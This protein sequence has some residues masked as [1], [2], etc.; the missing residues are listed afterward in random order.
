MSGA[1]LVLGAGSPMVREAA[2]LLAQRGEA[3]FLA[4]HDPMELERLA[5]DLRIRWGGRVAVGRFDALDPASH[6]ALFTRVLDAFG[7]LDRV[8]MASGYLGPVP[9]ALEGDEPGRILALNFSGLLPIL[10]LC[11]AHFERR[12]SG[13]ILGI[14]SV[15]G[16]RGRQSN[17][18]YGSAKGG[19]ALW[20]Q[21]LRNRLH[22]TGVRVVTFKPGFVDTAMTFGKPGIF[23]VASP[24][25]AGAALVRALDGGADIVYFPAFWRVIMALVRAIPERIFKGMKL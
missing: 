10:G 24:E 1:V 17:F 13:V 3:L 12:G 18:V 6:P 21:G 20:L 4:G 15:A 22:G 7:E 5:A 9:A 2:R 25:A 23:M 19:F 16:D 8:L 14:G 11:A